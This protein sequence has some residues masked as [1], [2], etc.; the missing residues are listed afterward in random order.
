MQAEAGAMDGKPTEKQ[1]GWR[2]SED[3]WLDAAYTILVENGVDA[4]KVM[5]LAKRLGLSRTS[6]YGHFDSREA[7]L[8]ALVDRWKAKNTG[9]LVARTERY[10]ESIGEAI[11]NLFD[12]WLR[13][14][15]FDA[16][17]D[18][19][20]RTWALADPTLREVLEAVDQER[21][22]AITAMFARHGYPEDQARVRAYAM[23]YTQIGYISMMVTEPVHLRIQRMPLYV[24]TF[25]GVP[26][27]EAE[28]ARFSARHGFGVGHVLGGAARDL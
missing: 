21:I 27:T 9:N 28:V 1:S 17:F 16:R 15:L 25:A 20:I 24:E 13:P 3:L 12:C 14:D 5:P 19:A 11:F 6:F 4:V 8:S 18:F 22:D 26:P 2:G 10:A 7:L 23:Y